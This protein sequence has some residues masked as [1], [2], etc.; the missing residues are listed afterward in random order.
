MPLRERLFWLREA[1]RNDAWARL[2]SIQAAS[3]PYMERDDLH[4]LMESIK[5]DLSYDETKTEERRQQEQD[6]VSR[7]LTGLQAMGARRR[8][9]ANV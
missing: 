1:R 9:P 6:K 5:S 8:T 4:G 2:W 3:A 7:L